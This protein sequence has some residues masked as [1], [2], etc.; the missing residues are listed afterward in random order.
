[1]NVISVCIKHVN[2]CP[3]CLIKLISIVR[4]FQLFVPIPPL[5]QYS[6]SKFHC[7][8]KFGKNTMKKFNISGL[9]HLLFYMKIRR[10]IIFPFSH[11]QLE[12]LLCQACQNTDN[13][14]CDS[15][16]TYFSQTFF[17]DYDSFHL[18]KSIRVYNVKKQHI[19]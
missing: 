6:Q 2:I 15:R 3:N 18:C 1:M 16:N 7:I 11:L 8:Y 17:V 5:H 19:I 10:L 4:G 14:F 9:L 13:T 12:L